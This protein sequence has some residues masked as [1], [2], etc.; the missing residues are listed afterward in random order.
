M[1]HHIA[2]QMENNANYDKGQMKESELEKL[3]S[4]DPK[5][6]VAIDAGVGGDIRKAVAMF[7]SH[8]PPD[9]AN[10][11]REVREDV[12]E[13]IGFSRNQMTKA[14]PLMQRERRWKS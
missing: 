14:E 13:I 6:A 9:L 5:V 10:A 4:G 7:Q 2:T 8:V 11:A 3:F 12:R 1:Q